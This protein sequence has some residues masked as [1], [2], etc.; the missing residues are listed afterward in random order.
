MQR[1]AML[2]STPNRAKKDQQDEED[3]QEVPKLRTH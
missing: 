2:D 1:F 3:A